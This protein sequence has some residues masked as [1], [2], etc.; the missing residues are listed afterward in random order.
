MN[1]LQDKDAGESVN[2]VFDFTD[3]TSDTIVTAVV[4][5]KL[6]RGTQDGIPEAGMISGAAVIATPFV[7]QAVVGGIVGN[8]YLL[9]CT[10]TT[11]ASPIETLKLAALQRIRRA[12]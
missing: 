10:I 5:A 9:T 6:Y 7:H 11:N 12:T 1:K 2:A 3:M 4:V 8:D